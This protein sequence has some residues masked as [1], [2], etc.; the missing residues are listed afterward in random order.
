MKNMIDQSGLVTESDYISLSQT[1]L[2]KQDYLVD[3][4]VGA[5]HKLQ[6]KAIQPLD[7]LE[8]PIPLDLWCRFAR[9]H[10]L[11]DYEI[12]ELLLFLN[13]IG[14]IDI[15]RSPAGHIIILQKRLKRLLT[16]QLPTSRVRRWTMNLANT[17]RA[18]LLAMRSLATASLI[19]V[20]LAFG[21]GFNIA[22]ATLTCLS[23]LAAIWFSTVL[24]EQVHDLVISRQTNQ[25]IL[26]QKN[27]RLGLLHRR[28][29][30]N[31]EL[32]SAVL[33]P[34]AGAMSSI[35]LCFGLAEIIGQKNFLYG[36]GALVAV[37]QL[38]SLLPMYGDG[39]IV[40]RNLKGVI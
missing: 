7:L 25:R 10:K 23:F 2:L 34:L 16:G 13:D 36:I 26:M 32:T 11:T 35:V 24:H 17:N 27:L 6:P 22:L 31:I 19:T 38:V 30:Q 5:K 28:L 20:L 14:G 18:V 9:S 4:I 40:W 1:L 33:G 15:S 29:P 3:L 8:Q 37:F 12:I 21:A 39:R